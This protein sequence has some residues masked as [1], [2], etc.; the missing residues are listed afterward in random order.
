MDKEIISDRQGV[1]LNTLYLLG[2]TLLIGTGGGVAKK[3]AWL[4]IILSV[5]ITLPV[6]LIYSK[7]LSL[8]HGKDLYQI[9]EIIFGKIAG[10]ILS[11][12]YIWF[13]LHLGA[14][15]IRNY[16]E[17][18]NVTVFPDMP[19]II[20]TIFLIVICIWGGKQGIE[21][22]GR[23]SELFIIVELILMLIIA[24]VLSAVLLDINNLRPV[25]ENGIKPVIYSAFLSF[26]FPFGE[27]VIL[28]LVY[29][30]LKTKKSSYKVF[31]KALIFAGIMILITTLRNIMVLGADTLQRLYFPA[32]AVVQI[33]KIGNFL[34]RMEISVTIAFLI[35]VFVK[36]TICLIG[37][38]TG[39][40]RLF[41]LD[42]Y[43][44]LVTP[45][46][47]TMVGLSI[48]LYSSTMEMQQWA[49]KVWPYYAVIFQLILPIIIYIGAMLKVKKGLS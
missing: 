27:T 10:K 33:I 48:T 9:V 3:D 22:L 40:S 49:F 42:D 6:M 23:W 19:V 12:L 30:C 18:T 37:A 32:Y 28:M 15:V 14:L 26:T 11:V 38:C 46:A 7:I 13:S 41:K 1:C 20:P 36:I 8:F 24:V 31:N 4:A 21:V 35:N 43:R 44:F 45:I 17:F 2:S 16:S 5:I 47:L 34:Q 39:I 29:S 25:L